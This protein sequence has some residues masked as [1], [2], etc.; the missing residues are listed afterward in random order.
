MTGKSL[1]RR[2]AE[3]AA[4]RGSRI[5]LDTLMRRPETGSLIGLVAVFGFSR[6]SGART[7]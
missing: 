1:D 5:S 6:F 4:P 7:F 2:S 3:G